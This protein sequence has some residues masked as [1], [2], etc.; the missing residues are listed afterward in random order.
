MQKKFLLLLI[1]LL[2][3]AT[4][5]GHME[6]ISKDMDDNY[7]N[8]PINIIVPFKD[9]SS[10]DLVARLVEAGSAKQNHPMIVLNKPGA[11]GVIGW[12]QLAESKPNGYTIGIATTEV[13]LNPLYYSDAKYDYPTALE[14][15]VQIATSPLLLVVRS[16]QPWKNVSD[17]IHDAKQH[18]GEIKYSHSGIG[19]QNH[20][21][22]EAFSKMSNIDM[23][24]VPFQGG[25]GAVTALLGGHVQAAVVT[26]AVIKEFVKNGT[27][28][29]L[30]VAGEQRM[31]DPLFATAPTFR[32]QGFDL[33]FTSHFGIAAPKDIP[34]ER[35][36]QLEQ[37]L[38]SIVT[39]PEFKNSIESMGLEYNYL[40]MEDT[41]KKWV[42]DNKKLRKAVQDT[43]ILKLILKEQ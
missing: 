23:R 25:S 38:N 33:V 11:S 22:G 32:E 19:T 30:A 34:I 12:N 6:N 36:K 43:G 17:L 16:D 5:I 27:V 24:Q 41:Q 10:P 20:I 37:Y 1:F 8:K 29:V 14:P 28:K 42:M 31:T 13:F 4:S 39:T 7:P 9:G 18:P 3:F 21:L 26:P 15:I 2:L 40:N 35:E